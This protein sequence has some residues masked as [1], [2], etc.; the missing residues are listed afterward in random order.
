MNNFGNP[1]T[2]T[3][4]RI[5]GYGRGSTARQ[6]M[7]VENQQQVVERIAK[8][9]VANHPQFL[10]H[11]YGGFFPE[12][13]QHGDKPWFSRPYGKQLYMQLR[14][15]DHII[16]TKLDR[17][18]RSASDICNNIRILN[19]RGVTIQSLHENID[20]ST[21]SGRLVAQIFGAVGEFELEMIRTRQAEIQAYKRRNLIP[22][23]KKQYPIGWRIVGEKPKWRF[24]EYYWE[25]E[26]CRYA[27]YLMERIGMSSWA[28]GRQ[29][30]RQLQGLGRKWYKNVG[31]YGRIYRYA[32]HLGFPSDIY[33]QELHAYGLYLE[34]SN[35]PLTPENLAAHKEDID[36]Q[37][38]NKNQA[39]KQLRIPVQSPVR[40]LKLFQRATLEDYE[41]WCERHPLPL[42]NPANY[43]ERELY[44]Q[45]MPH[46]FPDVEQNIERYASLRFNKH[47]RGF[48]PDELPEMN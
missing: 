12:R 1:T 29:V 2:A 35:I 14:P 47:D 30:E 46:L 17:A 18:C 15:G 39:T 22:L 31:H 37:T 34:S 11:E 40:A 9:L 16:I 21:A 6:D 32:Y 43:G 42:S 48:Q 33:S 13:A 44:K 10:H 19:E 26:L 36:T 23:S 4:R 5:F 45:R 25:R 3:V 8:G 41:R 20:I 27:T 7:T 28:T 24:H 38:F